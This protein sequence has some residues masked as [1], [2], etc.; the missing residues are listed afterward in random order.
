MYIYTYICIY[1]YIVN[2][3]IYIFICKYRYKVDNLVPMS[4]LQ[5]AQDAASLSDAL[6]RAHARRLIEC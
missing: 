4:T 1:V 6:Q 3:Y 5:R 2:I